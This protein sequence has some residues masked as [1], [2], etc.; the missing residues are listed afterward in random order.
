MHRIDGHSAPAPHAV[1][2]VA[3]GPMLGGSDRA[4]NGT[5]LIVQAE[6]IEAV[7]AFVNDDP[8]VHAGV[9]AS[10]DIQPWR[11]GIGP[12]EWIAP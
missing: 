3:A 6:S 4:M 2:V 9:Y 1:T 10:V 7:H 12:A 8:Y 11:C 5:L